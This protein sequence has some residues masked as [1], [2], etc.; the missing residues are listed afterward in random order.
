[1]A[2]LAVVRGTLVLSLSA[3]EKV[4]PVHAELRV[5]TSSVIAVDVLDDAV[6]AVH[7]VHGLEELGAA[8]P[9]HF[10]VG[11]FSSSGA[12]TFAVV[13]HDHPGGVRMWMSCAG[14]R[15]VG[16]HE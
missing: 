6:H 11:S 15:R 4:E 3:M 9:G 12:K 16:E 8:L 13:H 14:S 1:M 2:E 7:A 10:A 5:P